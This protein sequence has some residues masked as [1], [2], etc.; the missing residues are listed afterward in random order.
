MSDWNGFG[1]LDLSSVAEDTGVVRLEP[2]EHEVECVDAKIESAAS[3][4]NNKV[5]KAD[6]KSKAGGQIR[7]NFNV[8][9]SSAQAQEIGQRQL[10][11]FLTAGNHPNPDKPGDIGTLKGLS[12]KVVVG[13]GKPWIGQDGR[14]RQSPEVKVFL[15][16]AGAETA[17]KK[18]EM[19][20]EIPF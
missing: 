11:S 5:V 13:L 6:F 17:A 2:G 16:L 3:N 12:C 8:F 19:N 7:V 14:E 10:K 9:H 20:D 15:P 4:Q 1:S 18:D